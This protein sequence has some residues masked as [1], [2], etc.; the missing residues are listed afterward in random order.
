[1]DGPDSIYHVLLEGR[2]VGPY[3]RRTIVGMRI[4]KALR[5]EHVLIKQG[6]GHLTVADLIEA[7]SPVPFNPSRSGSFS[8]VQ[9]TY[10]AS[11]IGTRGRGLAVP[12]FKGEVEARVQGDVLRIAGRCRRALRWKD[13][14]VK[15]VLKHVVHACASGS[16]VDLWLRNRDNERLQL[17]AL[18]LF[19]ADT[20][21]ELVGWMPAATPP[22]DAARSPAP[23]GWRSPLSTGKSLGIAVLGIA[24]VAG[25]ILTLL[26]FLLSR[27]N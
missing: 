4:K 8:K 6:G 27:R 12:R 24:L 18:E 3:D 20:A 19:M 25:T 21:A 11:L 9:A 22:P 7:R 5:N 1:V 15:I 10:S 16:R 2:K 14:R 17:I 13:E 23:S 26:V